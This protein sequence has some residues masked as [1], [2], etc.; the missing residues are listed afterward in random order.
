MWADIREAFRVFSRQGGRLLGAG[1][2]F[3]SLLSVA[4]I[5]V[6]G[7]W[8]AGRLTREQAARAA[9]LEDLARW[10]GEG[11]ARTIGVLIDRARESTGGTFATVVSIALLIYAATRLVSGLERSIHL[12]WELPNAEATMR[13]KAMRQARK[14][15]AGLGLVLFA[16]LTILFLVGTQWALGFAATHV[17]HAP[18]LSRLTHVLISLGVTTLL[19]FLLFVGLPSA[20]IGWRDAVAGAALT[21]GFFWLGSQIVSWLIAYRGV[22]DRFGDAGTLVMLLLWISYSSQI[23]LLGTAFTGVRARRKGTLSCTSLSFSKK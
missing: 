10:V 22:A 12:L 9:L 1:I 19:F 3:Y 5:L 13:E 2:A 21:S 18:H 17:P 20:R 15:A 4:P 14:R 16:G 7:L 11:G 6:L 8:L 23:F